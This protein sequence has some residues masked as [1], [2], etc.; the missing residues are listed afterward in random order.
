MLAVSD[1]LAQCFSA[2]REHKLRA[3]LTALGLTMGVATLITVMTVVQ[4]ANLYVEQKIANLG[5][6]VFQIARTPFAVTD[7]TIVLKAL[8]YKKIDVTDMEAVAEGCTDCEEVGA[9]ASST[10]KARAGNKEVTDVNLYGQTANM[11][12][13]DTR[14]VD[15]GRYFTPSEVEHHTAVCMIGDTLVQQLFTGRDPVGKAIRLGNDE[16]IVIG[17]M[18]KIGSVL[19]QDQDNFVMVPLPVFL[20]MQ[21]VHT[22]LTINVKTSKQQFEQAQDQ[23]QLILRARRHLTSG[24]ENDFFIGTKESYMA[25]WRSI[26]TAFFA[27]FIMVS[28]ISVIIGGIVIM[29]VMLMSVTARKREIGVRRAVGATKLDIMRQF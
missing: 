13:I 26:S 17:V 10:V 24:M 7:F 25:L 29:N 12:D 22:S 21:G 15:L 27:V 5:T 19:G 6:N 11:A 18:E 20:R 14:A 23:A 16:L 4:G 9:T 3:S 1:N 28:A 2:L 8:K